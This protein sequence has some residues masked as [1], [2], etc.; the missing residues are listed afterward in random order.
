MTYEERFIQFT[1]SIIAINQIIQ[2]IKT[3]ALK[4]YG[5]LGS[6][7]N[8][9]FNLSLHP[10]GITLSKLVNLCHEDKAAVS[11]SIQRMIQLGIVISKKLEGKKYGATIYLTSNGKEIA[12]DLYSKIKDTIDFGGRELD[13]AH[14][15]EFYKELN[16]ISNNLQNKLDMQSR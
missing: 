5:L 3:N 12:N 9:L 14:R 8:C 15:I 1:H 10:E 13:E 7:A 16:S 2:K 11:R 4:E 6:D